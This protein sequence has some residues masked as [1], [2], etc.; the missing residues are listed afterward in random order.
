[1]QICTGSVVTAVGAA[2]VPPPQNFQS[3]FGTTPPSVITPLMVSL[4]CIVSV[5]PVL[6]V[7]LTGKYGIGLPIT[8][9]GA[10]FRPVRLTIRPTILPVTPVITGVATHS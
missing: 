10:A 3:A 5:A 9:S 6:S 8:L 4:V 7:V 2:N 1:M